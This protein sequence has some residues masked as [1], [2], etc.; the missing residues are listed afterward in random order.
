MS[1]RKISEDSRLRA[2]LSSHFDRQAFIRN[3]IKEGQ[4]SEC[5]IDIESSILD[6]N[7]EIKGYISKHT[8]GLMSGMQDF[9]LLAERYS[10]LSSVS[11]KLHRNVETLRK[12]VNVLLSSSRKPDL[13]NN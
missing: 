9:A 12:E 4:S 10:N 3:L 11:Q 7:F 1:I 5:L 13:N 8:D 2:F 6:I